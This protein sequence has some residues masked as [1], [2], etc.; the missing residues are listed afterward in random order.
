MN[1]D[2]PD[3][4][5]EQNSFA[6][7]LRYHFDNAMTRS[8]NFVIFLIIIAFLLGL[9]MTFV[10]MS[11]D[12]GG[13][14]FFDT[15][16]ISV[17]RILK[18]GKG[19]DWYNRLV[20]LLFWAF[21][22][23]ISGTIIGF[24]SSKIREIVA[25]LKKGKS[26]V[27]VKNH[28]VI[29]GWSNN[30]FP[31]LK[32]L[33]VANEDGKGTVVILS[34][35]DN[36]K[37]QDQVKGIR[38]NAKHLSIVTRT[39]NPEN[40][41]DLYIAN[42][43]AAKAIIVLNEGGD[44]DP[45]VITTVLAL[46]TILKNTDIPIIA[47]IQNPTYADIISSLE[48][49]KILP[50][51]T[52]NIIANVTAQA[53]RERGLGYIFLDFLDFDGD[54][55]YFKN[56]PEL[57]GKTYREALISFDQSS[58]LGII[59]GESIQLIPPSDTMVEEGDSLIFISADNSTIH[60]EKVDMQKYANF[61]P[62][63]YKE[64]FES[65]D[66]LFIGWSKIGAA[67][68]SALMPQL[69]KESKITIAYQTEIIDEEDIPTAEEYSGVVFSSV[70]VE[71]D[72]SNIFTI[73][74]EGKYD[75]VIILGY[76]EK[77]PIEHADTTTLMYLLKLDQYLSRHK[78]KTFR[79]VAQ[80]LD[81]SKAE[82]AKFTQTDELIISDNLSGLLMTQLSEN[83]QLQTVF[84]DLFD[85]KKSNVNVSPISKYVELGKSVTYA[86]IVYAAS[87]YNESAIGYRRDAEEFSSHQDG[88]Y[89]N[90]SKKTVIEPSDK[91]F[92]IVISH[93]ENQ[94]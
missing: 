6:E 54:E 38:K 29:L 28:T 4:R 18:L 61:S 11:Y 88:L 76:A 47:S 73:L 84:A 1:H 12:K 49:V 64:V 35:M 36:Q 70:Q 91:D 79:V 67:I 83:P 71:E 87:F 33:S 52:D 14:S 27:I 22:I 68:L 34:S 48:Q 15:W 56:V 7:K 59:K 2:S 20:S 42:P 77:L 69:S 58:V 40:A 24:L 9:F 74:E 16:W 82:L 85:E 53:C 94:S 10:Q 3:P 30:I 31:I 45:Q 92:I 55:I 57:S 75:E 26:G 43:L 21:S 62:S 13:K 80:M 72:F 19:N 41:E 89:L 50:V 51:M 37:M 5:N 39:G 90:P 44:K 86:D 46:G 66:V 60:Y 65:R 78:N 23:A 25:N 17:S 32:E 63:S 8:S 81:S 93:P